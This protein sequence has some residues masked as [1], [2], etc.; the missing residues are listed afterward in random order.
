MIEYKIPCEV[1]HQIAV[2]LY[3]KVGAF[4]ADAKRDNPDDYERFRIEYLA[5]QSTHTSTPIKRRYT[6]NRHNIGRIP[7]GSI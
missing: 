6:C 1:T 7:K 2:G 5:K 4:V 3:Q